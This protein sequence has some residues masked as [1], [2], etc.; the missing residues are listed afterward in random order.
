M[1]LLFLLSNLWLYQ[2]NLLSHF[3]TRTAP[4]FFPP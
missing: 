1:V 2:A 4:S 3:A